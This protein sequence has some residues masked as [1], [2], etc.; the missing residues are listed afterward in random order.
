MWHFKHILY[1]NMKKTYKI[2][3]KIIISI[4]FRLVFGC[5]VT[6]IW[7]AGYFLPSFYDMSYFLVEYNTSK[8]NCEMIIH[9][10]YDEVSA[11]V[12]LAK[13]RNSSLIPPFKCLLS[14][15]REFRSLGHVASLCRDKTQLELKCL[16][17][18]S[19]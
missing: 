19:L 14:R 18:T 12:L 15:L 2:R 8:H 17:R 16:C 3:I 11:F 6:T 7:S 9:I 1:T 4:V 13:A 5:I 10:S